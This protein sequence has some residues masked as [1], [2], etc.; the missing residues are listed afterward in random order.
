MNTLTKS[1]L[2]AAALSATAAA[3]SAQAADQSAFFEQQREMTDGYTPPF[4]VVPTRAQTKPATAYQ[5]AEDNWLTA[6]RARGPGSLPTPFPVANTSVATKAQPARL[7]QAA[8]DKAWQQ[9]R[10]ADNGYEAARFETFEHQLPL[11]DGTAQT[12]TPSEHTVAG[13]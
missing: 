10:K 4:N 11:T 5:I 8:Q 13:K 9:E 6:E 12:Y 3:L 1:I 2:L 7:S